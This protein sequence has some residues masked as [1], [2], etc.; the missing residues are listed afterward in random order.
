MKLD[1][2]GVKISRITG[3]AN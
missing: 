2:F 1:F 3:W